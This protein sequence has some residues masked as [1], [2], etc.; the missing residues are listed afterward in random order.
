MT[1]IDKKAAPKEANRLV[2]HELALK[3]YLDSLL[4]EDTPVDTKPVEQE[5]EI[6][7][8]PHAKVVV[9]TP[10]LE[11]VDLEIKLRELAPPQEEIKTELATEQ[12]I[13]GLPAGP[14]EEEWQDSSFECLMFKVAGS[15]TLSVPLTR[16]NGILPWGEK[17][18]SVPGHAEW[19]LG[20]LKNRGKQV[21]VVDIAKFVIPHNHKARESL[22][23]ERTFS[24]VILIDNGQFGLACDGLGDVLKLSKDKVRWRSDRSLRPWLAGTVI[25]QMCALID[26]DQF[27]SMLKEDGIPDDIS[28]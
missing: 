7:T 19:F 23:E 26:I 10:E 16:L 21:K 18:T 25:D 14:D 20:L 9:A 15:L 11:D 13:D 5:V 8:E 28:G 17:I 3:V 12:E 4:F 22:N 1:M 27:I 24:H 6:K 2:E